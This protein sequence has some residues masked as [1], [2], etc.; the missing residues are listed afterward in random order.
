MPETAGT[1]IR[2]DYISAEF[3]H[4]PHT[5]YLSCIKHNLIP[6]SQV[7]QPTTTHGTCRGPISVPMVEDILSEQIHDTVR[8]IGPYAGVRL[9]Y[10]TQVPCPLLASVAP[11]LQVNCGSKPM[12]M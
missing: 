3:V 5:M 2:I 10:A 8:H 11:C 9:R 4:F 7:I 12:G 6:Y 1:A